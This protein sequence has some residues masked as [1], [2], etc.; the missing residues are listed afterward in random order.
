MFIIFRV[1]IQNLPRPPEFSK[2]FRAEDPA[3]LRLG[4]LAVQTIGTDQQDIL[5]PNPCRDQFVDDQPDRHLA[6][7]CRLL[8]A[9][10]PIGKNDDAAA[11]GMSQLA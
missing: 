8:P 3:Q 7:T 5:M 10:H 6:M 11:A 9:F 1:V 4:I 2:Q